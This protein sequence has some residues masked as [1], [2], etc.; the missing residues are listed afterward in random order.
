MLLCLL[1]G[2]ADCHKVDRTVWSLVG[3]TPLATLGGAPGL[4]LFSPQ[5]KTTATSAAV[6]QVGANGLE[7]STLSSP[8][9]ARD[10]NPV[11]QNPYRG[12]RGS[13]ISRTMWSAQGG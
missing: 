3:A 10:V 12:P 9:G 5:I 7:P 1:I 4:T 11:V 2:L 13:L 8:Q 6:E